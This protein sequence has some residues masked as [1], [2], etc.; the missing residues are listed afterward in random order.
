MLRLSLQVAVV[1]YELAQQCS[2]LQR[3]VWP[4][5]LT[6][7]ETAANS[8]PVTSPDALSQPFNEATAVDRL[9][10]LPEVPCG[11]LLA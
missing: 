4:G 11:E 3:M 9:K 2:R 10:V 5:A 7:S 8:Q 6:Q 1:V